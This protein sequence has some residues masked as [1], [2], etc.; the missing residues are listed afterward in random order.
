MRLLDYDIATQY[1]AQVLETKRLTP[2][3]S[4]DEVRDIVLQVDG[5]LEVE[6]GQNV[7]VLAPG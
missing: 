3:D 2:A 1:E 6:V 7:G 4:S 5:G